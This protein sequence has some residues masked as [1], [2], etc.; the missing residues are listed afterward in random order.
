MKRVL[1]CAVGVTILCLTVVCL[2]WWR[3]HR[4]SHAVYDGRRVTRKLEWY[5]H[6]LGNPLRKSLYAKYYVYEGQPGHW[7]KQGPYVEYYPNGNV[8]LENYYVDD[9]QNGK[10]SIFN[11]AGIETLRIYWQQNKN[12]GYQRCPCVDP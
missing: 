5:G 4:E 2:L 10:E 6:G 8:R 11:E 9:Q 1:M 12:V 3:S 7:V